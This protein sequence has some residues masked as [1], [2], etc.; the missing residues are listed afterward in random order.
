MDISSLTVRG[1]TEPRVARVLIDIPANTEKGLPQHFLW[2]CPKPM[3]GKF[4]SLGE[5]P[6]DFVSKM[7]TCVKEYKYMYITL[8]ILMV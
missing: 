2:M 3:Y 8:L 6:M 5:L 7:S 4:S 1:F